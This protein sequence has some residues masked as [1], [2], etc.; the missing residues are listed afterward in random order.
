M[1]SLPQK[2]KSALPGSPSGQRH[3]PPARSSSEQRRAL[4]TGGAS[5]AAAGSARASAATACRMRAI[6][7]GRA[8]ARVRAVR[9][10]PG[11]APGL[12]PVDRP[13]RLILPMTA[14]RVT[15]ISA[16]IWL[17]VIPAVTHC[18][19]CCTRSVVQV[20]ELVAEFVAEFMDG[21]REQPATR[22]RQSEGRDRPFG[23]SGMAPPA[24]QSVAGGALRRDHRAASALPDCTPALCWT[25]PWRSCLRP[26]ERNPR[27]HLPFHDSIRP[28]RVKTLL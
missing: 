6:R 5:V 16:A 23:D 2:P 27:W 14:L 24:R 4:S 18:W 28:T 7:D 22:R 1:A 19:S 17:Q 11:I 25:P 21:P 10:R 13:R 20:V 8:G 9:I 3:P 15:P 26:V 12:R